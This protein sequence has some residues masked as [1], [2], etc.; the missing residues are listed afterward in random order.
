MSPVTQP[1]PPINKSLPPEADRYGLILLAAG[2]VLAIAAFVLEPV[3]ASF[4]AVI[5]YLFMVSLAVGALF[6]LALEYIT[7]AVW[8][9]PMRRVTEFFAGL[10][11][12]LLLL[13]L[14][15]FLHMH[16]LFHWTHPEAVQ[17][18]E[19]PEGLLASGNRSHRRGNDDA[20]LVVDR[21]VGGSVE[22]RHPVARSSGFHALPRFP[23]LPQKS[24]QAAQ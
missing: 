19:G 12:F 14:P 4:D 2:V 8:S 3:R 20:A 1:L 16:D 11:P 22:G 21:V 5:L 17:Q 13:V 24:P 23:P 15:L 7:G 18:D 9:V 6:L 10:S